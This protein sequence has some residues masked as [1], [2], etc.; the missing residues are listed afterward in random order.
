M[1]S[2]SLR[3]DHHWPTLFCLSTNQEQESGATF[4]SVTCGGHAADTSFI[5]LFLSFVCIPCFMR[6]SPHIS[7]PKEIIPKTLHSVFR[8]P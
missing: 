5:E 8:K 3:S 4:A 2:A 1:A 6:L 7:T